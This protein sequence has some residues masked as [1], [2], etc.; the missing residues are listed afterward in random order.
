MWIRL[1]DVSK[2]EMAE[3][4]GLKKAKLYADEDI[5]PAVVEF[6]N[7]RGVNV[8]SALDLGHIQKPDT[9]HAAFAFKK[10]RFVLTRNA[11]HF[12]DDRLL[13]FHSTH[14]VIAIT[15]DM[16]DTR[17]YAASLSRVLDLVPY[18]EV[19]TGMKILCATQYVTVRL[20]S[21]AGRTTTQRFKFTGDGLFQWIEDDE[22]GGPTR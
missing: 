7:S 2:E 6:L 5:E 17:A 10:K 8:V 19:Y 22:G 9:F 14:G 12:L 15:G 20:I 11:K 13:P 4:R 21:A 16:S 18:G 1:P 3:L